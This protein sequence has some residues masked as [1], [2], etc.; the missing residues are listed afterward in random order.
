MSVEPAPLEQ[1][2]LRR[3]GP[4]CAPHRP[5]CSARTWPDTKQSDTGRSNSILCP[6]LAAP[7]LTQSLRCRRN[8]R[9]SVSPLSSGTSRET[10]ALQKSRATSL[11]Y[12]C[13]RWPSQR[14]G[15]SW[16]SAIGSRSWGQ[17]ASSPVHNAFV[18][19]AVSTSAQLPLPSLPIQLELVGP[20]WVWA[21]APNPGSP[22]SSPETFSAETPE[23][24]WTAKPRGGREGDVPARSQGRGSPGRA[25]QLS[26][27]SGKQLRQL[28][29]P[30]LKQV[31]SPRLEGVRP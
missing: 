9:V 28:R 31:V 25:I 12:Y 4:V 17:P 23:G 30:K 21:R 24:L 16:R 10:Q 7:P 2:P 3:R 22:A 19:Y 15:R 5:G 26:A 11:E 29:D 13:W 14:P 18:A 8:S 1:Q 20:R 27:P 6:S